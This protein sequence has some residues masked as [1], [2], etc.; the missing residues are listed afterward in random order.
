[1][2]PNARARI[3]ETQED[4]HRSTDLH[5]FQSGQSYHS[6][7]GRMWFTNCQYSQPVRLLW[8]SQTGQ[9][10]LAKMLPYRTEL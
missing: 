5:V 4:I 2:E 9:H 6:A 10:Q 7:D 3:W 1:M 8:H